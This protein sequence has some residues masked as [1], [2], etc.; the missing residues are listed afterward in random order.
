MKINNYK[1]YCTVI[2]NRDEEEI[3][4]DKNENNEKDYINFIEFITPNPYIGRK[5][6]KE[7]LR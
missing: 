5:N 4:Y 3:V 1:L 2:N 6:D 7:I